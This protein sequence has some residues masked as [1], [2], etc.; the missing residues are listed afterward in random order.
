MEVAGSEQ[1]VGDHD[2]PAARPSGYDGGAEARL[3]SGQ[4]SDRHL[5]S[6]K[7][8]EHRCRRTAVLVR[9]VVARTGD[10]QDDRVICADLERG[11][12]RRE[13]LDEPRIGAERRRDRD[14]GVTRGLLA[15]VDADVVARRQQQGNDDDGLIGRERVEGC[16]NVGLLH[17][18]VSEPD[19][20]GRQLCGDGL[21][22]RGD[23]G[24]ACGGGRAVR[25]REESRC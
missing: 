2:A 9:T 19:G 21:H 25:D 12:P 18:Y 15:E 17:V 23:R 13:D 6:E 4:E 16:R 8:G 7:V 24:L 14:I 3:G 22:E 10:G 11:E 1:I 5:A 20:D